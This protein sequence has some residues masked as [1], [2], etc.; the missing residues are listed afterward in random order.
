MGKR[1]IG[2]KGVIFQ[3]GITRGLEVGSIIKCADNS[4]VKTARI[5]SVPKYKA[6]YQQVPL[7]TIGS[8]VVLAVQ[9]GTPDMRRKIVRGIIV[10]QRQHFR[11]ASG[12]HIEF[13]DNAVVIVTDTGDPKG[14]EISGPMAKE[15][16]I[17]WPRL[18]SIA[19][20]II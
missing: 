13:E 11:R 3:P 12:Q 5:I 15:A 6:H 7:A 19:S 2:K 1:K 16:A 17:L 9:K 8:M 20:L 4:G 10:R 18:A 14:T